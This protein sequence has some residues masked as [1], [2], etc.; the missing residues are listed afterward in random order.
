MRIVKA[1]LKQNNKD[2][3]LIFPNFKICYKAR[4]IKTVC[5]WHKERKIDK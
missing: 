3:K 5:H 1:T 2:G 4:V